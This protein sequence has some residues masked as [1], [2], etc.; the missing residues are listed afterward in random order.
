[1]RLKKYL[2]FLVYVFHIFRT[3]DRQFIRP[4][5]YLN[6]KGTFSTSNP[7]L[8]VVSILIYEQFANLNLLYNNIDYRRYCYDLTRVASRFS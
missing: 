7:I 5:F 3:F 1:M 8:N 2:I 6:L 4:I